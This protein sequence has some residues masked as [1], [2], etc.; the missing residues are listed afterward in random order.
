MSKVGNDLHR[1][2][3]KELASLYHPIHMKSVGMASAALPCKGGQTHP[4]D[5]KTIVK[6]V[7]ET[8]DVRLEDPPAK[9]NSSTIRPSMKKCVSNGAMHTQWGSGM[10]GGSTEVAH[11]ALEASVGIARTNKKSSAVIF[12]DVASAFAS[13]EKALMQQTCIARNGWKLNFSNSALIT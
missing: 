4:I 5:K 2:A 13:I 7:T 8:R 9:I 11:L 3:P 12:V 6:R 1:A 10:N